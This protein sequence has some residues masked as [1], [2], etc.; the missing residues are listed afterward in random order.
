[1]TDQKVKQGRRKP[2]QVERVYV[3]EFCSPGDDAWLVSMD[4]MSFTVK[5][6]ARDKANLFMRNTPHIHYRVATFKREAGA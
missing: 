4:A 1:M 2:R 6:V 5:E 3:L